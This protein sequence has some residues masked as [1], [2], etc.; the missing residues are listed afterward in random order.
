MS[1][2]E[3][4]TA[5]SL[6]EKS[7]VVERSGAPSSSGLVNTVPSGTPTLR[8]LELRR[9]DLWAYFHHHR[10]LSHLK[11]RILTRA[12]VQS[13]EAGPG[14]TVELATFT[15]RP[16]CTWSPRHIAECMKRYREQAR[17]DSVHFRYEWVAELQTRR[18]SALTNDDGWGRDEAAYQCMHYHA[19]IWAPPGYSWPKPDSQGW[20][21]HGMTQVE[22][23]DHPAAYLAKYA[24]KGSGGFKMPKGCRLSGGGG[25]SPE[26]RREVA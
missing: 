11:R 7:A 22:C 24:S 12:R 23:A 16:G 14:H 17:R 8:Q 26:G 13:D 20:W 25:L 6:N 18:M 1:S 9:E 15:Y 4:W 10:R 5:P 2:S 21:R 19:L 3:R